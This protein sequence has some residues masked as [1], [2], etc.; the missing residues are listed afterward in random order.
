MGLLYLP[1]VKNFYIFTIIILNLNNSYIN[2]KY[3][4]RKPL[5]VQSYL[6]AA[7]HLFLIDYFQKL[8]RQKLGET[9]LLSR[10][11]I[12]IVQNEIKKKGSQNDKVCEYFISTV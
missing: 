3:L 12:D 10:Y 4:C 2:K 11:M 8:L 9:K 5:K 7:S 6:L 1:Q